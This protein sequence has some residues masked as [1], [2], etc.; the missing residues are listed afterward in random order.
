M[1]RRYVGATNVLETTYRT[2][3][4]VVSVTDLMP[5]E[6]HDLQPEREVLRIIDGLT[7]E[8]RMQVIFEPRPD[9]GRSQARVGRRSH[10]TFA[11]EHHGELFLLRTDVHLAIDGHGES[12]SGLVPIRA[13]E[14]RYLS[15]SYTRGTI[16][17][18]PALGAAADH[19]LATALD[20]WN[21]WS[22]RCHY[23]GC[24]RDAVIRSLLTVKLMAYAL[25]GAIV[26]APTTSLP[27]IPGGNANWDY[28]YCWLRDA[29]LAL[30]SLMRL[31]YDIE[32]E[33]FLGWLLHATRLTQPRLQVMY[34]VY[35]KA[36]LPEEELAHLEGYRGA[37]P[38]RI[39]NAASRQLQ[40]DVYA[41]LQLTIPLLVRA[42][43]V[44]EG[45]EFAA[46]TIRRR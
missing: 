21:A 33:A 22:S 14:R 12:V 26:A 46:A 17:V 5:V 8:A 19:R 44:L 37:W 6:L 32:A 15:F 35:G 38:V 10:S 11:C 9:Y 18:L 45:R 27:E 30:Q 39:G 28:R 1:T 40:L 2:P 36:D 31:G 25:S 41:R 43:E 23:Q 13:G 34:D 4:G 16:G 20:W 42:T 24:H 7:G 29:A 3:S